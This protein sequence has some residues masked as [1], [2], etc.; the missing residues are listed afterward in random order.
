MSWSWLL[1]VVLALGALVPLLVGVLVVVVAGGGDGI[2][3]VA[4]FASGRRTLS[5]S[6]CFVS[7]SPRQALA[8]T[9]APITPADVRRI[10]Q[11]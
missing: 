9:R 1:L 6:A 11:H 4:L 8:P 10:A 3:L 7:S 2:G 5:L